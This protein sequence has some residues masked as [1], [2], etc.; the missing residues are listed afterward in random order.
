MHPNTAARFLR[1]E[2]GDLAYYEEGSIHAETIFFIHGNSGSSLIWSPQFNSALNDQYRLVAIDLPGQGAS[3]R[4]HYPLDDYS[5][6]RTGSILTAAV[7]QLAGESPFVLVGFSYGAN[8]IGEMIHEGLQPWGIVL[9]APSILG[10]NHSLN[11][12]FIAHDPPSIFVYNESNRAAVSNWIHNRMQAPCSTFEEIISSDY[13]RTDALFRSSLLQAAAEGKICDE[14]A[15]L[16]DLNQP[17][18]V[19]FG[20]N[21]DVVNN[22]Y[23]DDQPFPI[24]KQHIHIIPGAGH[25][26][27]IEQQEMFNRILSEY[28]Q[29]RFKEVHEQQHT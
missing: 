21:D 17:V 22:R 5:P 14:I 16:K 8:L 7:Q 12:I 15:A 26:V 28:A 6:T 9:D 11:Q 18:C 23:L 3:F 25:W 29:E 20:E 13:L 10:A 24:W 4:S 27:H 19:L 2:R 1:T